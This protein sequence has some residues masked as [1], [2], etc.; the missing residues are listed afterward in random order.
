MRPTLLAATLLAAPILAACATPA[1]AQVR[2]SARVRDSVL[3]RDSARAVLPRSVVREVVDL[4][5][6]P[7]TLRAIGPYTLDSADVVEGDL[8]VLDGPVT[9]AGHVTGRVVAINSDVTLRPGARVRGDLL[10]V[11]GALLTREGATVHGAVRVY[12][13]RL[14]YREEGDMIVPLDTATGIGHFEE[15]LGRW[16]E[17]RQRPGVRFTLSTGKTYN[18]VEGLPIHVGPAYADR[19]HWGEVDAAALGVLRTADD[20]RWDSENLG[21]LAHAEVRLGV[22]RGLVLGGRLYDAVRPVEAWHLSEDEVGLASFFFHRDYRDYFGAHGGAVYAGLFAGPDAELEAYLADERWTDRAARDPFSL[23]RNGEPWRPNPAADEGR[24]HVAGLTLRVDTRNLPE[25]TRAGVFVTAE[26]ERGTGRV[27]RFAALS[28]G[29]R[30]AA[31]PRVTYGRGF[32]DVRSYN[33]VA[34]DAQV[35]L[36]LVAGGWL[37]GDPL[38]AQRRLSV[39]GAGTLPGFD[40]RE[41]VGDVDV[42]TCSTTGIPAGSP[43]QCDRVILLQGEYRGDLRANILGDFD[44]AGRWTRPTQWVVFLDT[45]RGWLVGDRPGDPLAVGRGRLPKLSS[46]RTDVGAGL[47]LGILGIFVAKSVS[48]PGLRANFHI[49]LHDR[50]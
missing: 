12:E 18:R 6:D 20:L 17:K 44:P 21:H 24:F 28:P 45:G 14:A 32:L 34:P 1:A 50:F 31:D 8:A 3:V 27:T 7:A 48:D 5:N 36:R 22:A 26:Y 9:L 37:H 23:F 13:A 49:R 41:P 25:A 40:F 10:V 2:D 46:Y 33:R 29:V 39:G 4:Y 16:R 35:N 19:F 38:P 15:W 47:D 11:G 43:A 30:E 42:G